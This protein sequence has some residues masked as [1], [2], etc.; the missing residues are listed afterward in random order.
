MPGLRTV[1]F[2]IVKTVSEK[3]VNR[4]KEIINV[5]LKYWF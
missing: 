1:I 2:V 5:Y 4:E 3:P